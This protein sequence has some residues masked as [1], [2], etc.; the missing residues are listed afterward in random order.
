MRRFLTLLTLLI[1]GACAPSLTSAAS[2]ANILLARGRTEPTIAVDPRH[3]RTIVAVT[4][5]NYGEP[6][7]GGYPLGVFSSADGGRS[8]TVA[9]APLVSPYTTEAD[10]SVAIDGNGTTFISILG[11]TPGYCQGG[12]SAIVVAHSID[13]GRSFR[14]PRIV[15]SDPADDK[16]SMA[17][18][19]LPGRLSHIFV[20]WTRFHEA[21]NTSDVWFS[22]SL[23][24]GAS[25][26][27]PVLLRSSHLNSTGTVPVVGPHGRIYV[28]WDDF[29]DRPDAHAG[30]AHILLRVSTDDGAHFGPIRDISQTFTQLPL[31]DSPGAL[32]VLTEP[33]VAISSNGT[34]YLA[35]P[36]VRRL[37]HSAPPDTDI[38]LRR[39][40]D[41]ATTWSAPVVVNDVRIADRFMPAITVL[42]TGDVG[43]AFYDR[44][45]GATQLDLY[46]ARVSFRHGVTVFPNVRINARP[47]AVSN[48][49]YLP[50]NSTCFLPGRFFGDYIGA[51]SGPNGRLCVVWSD[52]QLGVPEETDIW[53][54]SRR[55]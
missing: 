8:F 48:I 45:R 26:R 47:S 43:L 34:L 51:A 9:T 36:R 44:R 13:H 5:T 52:T 4:N 49:Q 24:G 17:V 10:P 38:V 29:P 11:E 6:V 28:F 46:A 53:F 40:T 19:T 25:F 22:R 54:A 15:D 42:S 14:V 31:N 37:P 23:D 2:P 12:R 30:P 20:T 18:Q 7:G 35:W 55:I 27:A 41:G 1:A 50:P 39:S 33:S 32:R 21:A 3:P 16:P